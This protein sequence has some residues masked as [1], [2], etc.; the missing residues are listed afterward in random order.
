MSISACENYLMLNPFYSTIATQLSFI[1]K[2]I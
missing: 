2:N 1:F